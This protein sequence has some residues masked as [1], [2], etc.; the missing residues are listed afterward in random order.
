MVYATKA[1]LKYGPLCAGA[2]V[3]AGLAGLGCFRVSPLLS[4]KVQAVALV[5]LAIAMTIQGAAIFPRKWASRLVISPHALLAGSLMLFAGAA[6]LLAMLFAGCT[7]AR[8]K[9]A[10]VANINF[11]AANEQFRGACFALAPLEALKRSCCRDDAK[12]KAV[13]KT[14]AA[15]LDL[16]ALDRRLC[17]SKPRQRVCAGRN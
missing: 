1:L 7:P 2:M 5:A 10:I 6:L 4:G 8:G 15:V 17:G 11:T 9:V 16:G 12:A 13:P 3:C 14:V